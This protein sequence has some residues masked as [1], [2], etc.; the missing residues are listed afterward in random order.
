MLTGET[1]RTLR[2]GLI[3]SVLVRTL[4]RNDKGGGGGG[5]AVAVHLNRIEGIIKKA[6]MNPRQLK[7]HIMAVSGPMALASFRQHSRTFPTML[8]KRRPELLHVQSKS[9]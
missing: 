7:I 9:M 8:R 6:D 1:L 5:G 3:V 2:T 4:K